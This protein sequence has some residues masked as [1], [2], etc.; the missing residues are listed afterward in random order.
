VRNQ[1]VPDYA[2]LARLGHVNRARMTQIMNLVLLAP[3]IQEQL[4][5]L[6]RIVRGRDPVHLKQL[7]PIALLL[8][9]QQQRRQWQRLLSSQP[10]AREAGGEVAQPQIPWNG[11]LALPAA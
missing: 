3:D 9:W 5:F 7:Q 10:P 4:L 1:I 6:P 2:A 8:D 11:R